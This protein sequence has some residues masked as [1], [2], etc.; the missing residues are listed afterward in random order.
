MIHPAAGNVDGNANEATIWQVP[1]LR[2]PRSRGKREG[3]HA[4]LSGL[5]REPCPAAGD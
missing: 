4:L 3:N 1:A 5:R 2:H